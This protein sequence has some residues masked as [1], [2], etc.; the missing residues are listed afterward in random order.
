MTVPRFTAED[1]LGQT[2][3][4]YILTPGN[5][6]GIEGVLPQLYVSDAPICRTVCIGGRCFDICVGMNGQLTGGGVVNKHM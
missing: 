4:R 3:E 1:S 6:V 2:R 5:A